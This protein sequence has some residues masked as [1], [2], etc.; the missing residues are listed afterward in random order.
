[1]TKI[2]TTQ[3]I[4]G[5]FLFVLILCFLTF[6]RFQ[7]EI[8]N[9]AGE[10]MF[11]Q[12]HKNDYAIKILEY[13]PEK[14]RDFQTYFLLGRLYFV[15]NNLPDSIQNY[16]KSIAINPDFK[17]NYYGRG[18]AFGFASPVFYSDA[19]DNFKKYIEIDNQNF[20]ETGK[21]AYGAWAGYNDLAWI[22]FMEG[23]FDDSINT[24]EAGLKI[25]YNSPW[26]LNMLGTSLLAQ[27]K[28]GEAKKYLDQAKKEMEKISV[29]QFGEAYS[30]DS[31]DFWIQGKEQMQ[32]TINENLQLCNS[33]TT[34]K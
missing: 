28:C 27:Q 16:S 5:Y 2:S 1:M 22:Y 19:E 34:I 17:E 20:I 21:H 23:N 18:L 29:G 26:L 30:G 33:L 24:A 25:G 12:F 13:L 6:F 3:K 14:K 15:T 8:L 31:P 4:Y 7:T 32:K 10:K 9:F 11:L